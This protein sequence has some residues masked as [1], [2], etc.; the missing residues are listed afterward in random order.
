MIGAEY[1]PFKDV[2][3]TA[4]SIMAAVGAIGLAW[5]GRANWEPSE[6]DVPRG[7][8]KVGALVAA[9][10][11]ALL[12]A[13]WR[14]AEHAGSLT[15]LAIVLGLCTI[16]FLLLYGYLVGLQTYEVVELNGKRRIIGGFWLTSAATEA[17]KSAPGNV[18]V[19]KLLAGAAY[20]PDVLWSR[21]SRQ[22]AKIAFQCG[23][24]GLT[25]SGTVALAAAAI[26][27]GLAVG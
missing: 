15:T 2:V 16:A 24:L 19:Q 20:D 9:I 7:A 5:R 22:L 18:T 3:A 8:Q 13:E 25:I 23:Y 26:R 11:I 27:V 12:W 21:P 14:T 1:G 10:A 17:R 6:E 4:G